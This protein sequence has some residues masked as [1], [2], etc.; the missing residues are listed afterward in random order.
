MKSSSLDFEVTLI[1]FIFLVYT[2]TIKHLILQICL[3]DPNLS[4]SQHMS[5]LIAWTCF[6]LMLRVWCI[7][8]LII[9][10][11]ILII[12]LSHSLWRRIIKFL[13]SHYR[14]RFTWSH[15]T[16]GFVLMMISWITISVWPISQNSETELNMVST[17]LI[18]RQIPSKIMIW[19]V[20]LYFMKIV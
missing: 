2:V 14:I 5:S 12:L 20:K 8:C 19:K 17:S 18:N 16:T 9:L 15:L 7:F 6:L 10:L 13:I 1:T 11:A 3:A 4:K